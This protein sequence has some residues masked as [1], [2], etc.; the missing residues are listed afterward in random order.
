MEEVALQES[1][2][3]PHAPD[4][5]HSHLEPQ[6]HQCDIDHFGHKHDANLTQLKLHML[7]R[8]RFEEAIAV[9]TITDVQPIYGGWVGEENV[10][11]GTCP[12]HGI[13]TDEAPPVVGGDTTRRIDVEAGAQRRDSS[14]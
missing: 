10:R 13:E 7:W 3:A 9:A 14:S 11:E 2:K 5:P 8:H 12:H 6:V 4:R 1:R